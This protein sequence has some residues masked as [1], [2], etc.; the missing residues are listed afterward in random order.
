MIRVIDTQDW[1][2]EAANF[3]GMTAEEYETNARRIGERSAREVV[4]LAIAYTCGKNKALWAEA[5]EIRLPWH[6]ITFSITTYMGQRYN[7]A[8]QRCLLPPQEFT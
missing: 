2:R 5:R 6:A 3:V 4:L 8:V 7:N 1:V